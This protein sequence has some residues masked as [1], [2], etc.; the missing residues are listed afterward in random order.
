MYNEALRRA[1]E[2]GISFGSCGGSDYSTTI[3]CLSSA[4][5]KLGRRQ[6]LH[7]AGAAP[8]Y[9]ALEGCGAGDSSA[10][11]RVVLHSGF[12]VGPAPIVSAVRICQCVDFPVRP[13]SDV[14]SL[15]EVPEWQQGTV[16]LAR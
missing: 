6:L 15:L 11:A 1:A 13:D 14:F 3:L 7:A 12:L 4:L 2:P 16:Y 9:C 10:G 5:A 8:V